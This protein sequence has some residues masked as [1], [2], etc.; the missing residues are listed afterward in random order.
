MNPLF[1]RIRLQNRTPSSLHI[2]IP[3]SWLNALISRKLQPRAHA[4]RTT[5]SYRRNFQS[6]QPTPQSTWPLLSR[7][8]YRLGIPLQSLLQSTLS[9]NTGADPCHPAQRTRSR[10]SPPPPR[11]AKARLASTPVQE[12]FQARRALQRRRS[13]KMS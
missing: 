4:R 7:Q 11:S 13:A 10:H 6:R 1:P 5:P 3:M 8:G 12:S 2:H 9:S